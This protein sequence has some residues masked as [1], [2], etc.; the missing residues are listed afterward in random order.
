MLRRTIFPT[1]NP[2]PRTMRP[3]SAAIL[4]A[5]LMPL[6]LFAQEPADGFSC[7]ANHPEE[8][9]RHLDATPGALER[10]M[11]A[12]AELDA[13]TLGFQRGGERSPYVIPVVM[14][15]IHNNGPE[16]ITDAQVYDQ[17]RILNEDFNKLNPDWQNVHPDF[18][19][20]V[21]DVG[22]EFRLARKDPQGNCTNGIT[23]TVS[24]LTYVGDYE[25]TQLIQWP[26]DRY[27]N[28]WICAVAQG[29]AGYTYYPIWLDDWPEADGI[30]ILS[31][32]VGSIG[33]SNAGRSRVLSHEVGH[34]LNLKHCWGDSNEPG[35]ESNCFMDDDVADTPLTRGWTSCVL[36]GA[37]CGSQRD[38]VENYMEYSYCDKMFTDGQADRMI[39]SLTSSIAQRNNLW[40]PAT[41]LATG[42]QGE[43]ELCLAQ[44]ANDKREI[45]AGSTISFRDESYHSITSRTWSFPGGTPATSSAEMPSVQYDTPGVYTVAL[46]VSDGSTNSVVEKVDLVTVLPDPGAAPPFQ[47]G[48]EAGLS[49]EEWVVFDPD[50]GNGFAVTDVAAYTGVR[51]VRLANSFAQDGRKD[52][53]SSTTY[54]MSDADQIT[55]SYRYAYARRFGDN[56]DRL[57]LYVSRDCGTTWSLRQ[58]L[59]GSTTLSTAPNTNGG[60]IPSGPEQWGFAEVSNISTNF[61]SP[62]FRFRFE[63]ESNGGNDLYLDDVNINGQPVGLGALQA[64]DDGLYVVP[65]PAK[66]HAEAI[67]DLG[68]GGAMDLVVLD[69][70]GRPTPIALHRVLPAGQHRIPLPIGQLAA[71]AY[72]LHMRSAA[73]VNVARFVVE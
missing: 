19:D 65:N 21:G 31:D 22:I 32:Y 48:F 28:V 42:V 64:T 5:A 4:V 40:Q 73:L 53:L 8:L 45:C 49:T 55:I 71:G 39:A 16:N 68:I 50:G 13:H 29:A 14:H 30:V 36:N 26:R 2:R 59:R 17:I 27:M 25:T 62:D 35:D 37:S 63:F 52:D 57:R 6:A 58:Q 1:V 11:Q 15:I 51:S 33:T 38:N 43:G 56:D 12:K 67:I 70:L 61:H 34:W 46:Q 10:A 41:L 72:V 9:Q 44:F 66:G 3:L 47:D 7:L 54:D 20:R 23:R 60:F 24:P 69:A 18:L